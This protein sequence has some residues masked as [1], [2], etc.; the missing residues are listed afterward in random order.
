[1]WPLGNL[2]HCRLNLFDVAVAGMVARPPLTYL[3]M[4]SL[5]QR[6][7]HVVITNDKC[8][9]TSTNW[10]EFRFFPATHILQVEAK[11]DVDRALYRALLV[12]GGMDSVATNGHWSVVTDIKEHL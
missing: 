7:L 12:G 10:F 6:W 2:R 9:K 4:K 3:P 5:I 11:V 1:M 8:D